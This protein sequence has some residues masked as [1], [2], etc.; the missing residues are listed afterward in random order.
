MN[1]AFLVESHASIEGTIG[2]EKIQSGLSIVTLARPVDIGLSQYKQRR[3][4]LVPLKLNFVALEKSLLRDGVLEKRNVED[5][6][7]GGLTLET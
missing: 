6:D 4:T 1:W 3:A 7:N 5:L 2:A